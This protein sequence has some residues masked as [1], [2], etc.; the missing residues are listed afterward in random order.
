M[1]LPK[2]AQ[3]RPFQY[4]FLNS[5]SEMTVTN[6]NKHLFY[7]T[8]YSKDIKVNIKYAFKRKFPTLAMADSFPEHE[9]FFILTVFDYQLR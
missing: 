6:G 3:L 9:S 8:I 2:Q 1:K 5:V 7:K 4:H